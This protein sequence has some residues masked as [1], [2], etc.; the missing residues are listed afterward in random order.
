MSAPRGAAHAMRLR[1]ARPD[2]AAF[3]VELVPRFTENGVAGGHTRGEVIEG[4]S[5]VLR[6]A[7]EEPVPG[8]VLLIAEDGNAQ[9]MGFVY[10]VTH[11]DFFTGEAYLHVSEIAAVRSG[12]GV[13][14]VLMDAVETWARDRGDRIVTL[15]VVDENT[16]AQRF[17]ARRGFV[18]AHRQYVKRL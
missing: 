2:D 13:G 11:R 12:E 6:A 9:P 10:A 8:Q 1:E 3:I 16:A 14:A 5:H 15:N 7:L 18:I 17:Y 4:T